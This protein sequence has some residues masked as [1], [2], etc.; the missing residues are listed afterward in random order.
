MA[1]S[2]GSGSTLRG[3]LEDSIPIIQTATCCWWSCSASLDGAFKAQT[4]EP[5]LSILLSPFFVTCNVDHDDD[6][7]GGDDDDDND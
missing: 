4:T 6:D 7:D 2:A 5:C 3:S 1:D